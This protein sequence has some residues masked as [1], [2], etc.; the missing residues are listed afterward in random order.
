[1]KRIKKNIKDL[2]PSKPAPQLSLLPQAGSFGNLGKENPLNGLP[3]ISG[4]F[5]CRK[6]L[7]GT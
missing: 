7:S 2:R 3:S 1:M 4:V 5:L 6:R